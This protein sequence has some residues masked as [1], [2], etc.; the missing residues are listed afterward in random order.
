MREITATRQGTYIQATIKDDKKADVCF[1]CRDIRGALTWATSR[2][3]NYYCIFAQK[4]EVNPQGK[5]PLLLLAEGEA[6]LPRD[7]FQRLAKDARRYA[8]GQFY[9]DFDRK[10]QELVNLFYD[11]CQYQRIPNI[12]LTKAPLIENFSLGVA[13]IRE[14]SNALEIP[15]GTILRNQLKDMEMSD[16]D[17]KPEERFYAVNALRFIVASLPWQAPGAFQRQKSPRSDP[18]GWT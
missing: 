7:L 13:L 9:V 1:F 8:C 11:Y 10:N 5:S 15:Q 16:V 18:G 12:E 3:P 4:N 17:D 14:W 6:G 2:S